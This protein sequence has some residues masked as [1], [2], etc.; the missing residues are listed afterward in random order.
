MLSRLHGKQNLWWFTDGHWTK[1]VSSSRSWHNVHFNVGFGAAVGFGVPLPVAGGIPSTGNDTFVWVD[2]FVIGGPTIPAA[3]FC[4]ASDDVT[5]V[6]DTCRDP[7]DRRPLDEPK[8]NFDW[9]KKTNLNFKIKFKL[10]VILFSILPELFGECW[11][12][13]DAVRGGGG[14]GGLGPFLGLPGGNVSVIDIKLAIGLCNDADGAAIGVDV[15]LIDTGGRA[16]GD[17]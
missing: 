8:W 2:G 6:L 1:C 10:F 4:W 9:N 15:S 5:V 16:I 3:I 12:P 17:G 14:P 13:R 7:D 11:L